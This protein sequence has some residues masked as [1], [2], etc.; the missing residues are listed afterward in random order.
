VKDGFA[1]SRAESAGNKRESSFRHCEEQSDEA[2]QSF[3]AALDCFASLAMTAFMTL[4][5]PPN[6][7]MLHE[8]RRERQPVFT[9]V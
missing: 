4:S 1:K 7:G 6:F 3:L 5:T 8:R 9:P 2:I